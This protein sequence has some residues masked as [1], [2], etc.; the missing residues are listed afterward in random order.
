MP[1]TPVDASTRRPKRRWFQFSLRTLLIVV[2][3]LAVWLGLRVDRANRQQEAVEAIE[4]QGGDVYYDYQQKPAAKSVWGLTYVDKTYSSQVDPP[5]AEWLRQLV[6]ERF[7]VT[8]VTVMISRQPTICLTPLRDLPHLEEVRLSDTELSDFDVAN[9]AHLKKLRFL[10]ITWS[11][12]SEGGPQDFSFLSHLTELEWLQIAGCRFSEAGLEHLKHAGKLQTLHVPD[13]QI[14][15]D[16]LASLEHLSNL[17]V[18]G[19]RGNPITDDGLVHIA[20]LNKLIWLLLNGTQVTDEGLK[21]LEGLSGLR[22]LNLSKT[23]VTDEGLKCLE[24]LSGLRLLDLRK[25]Q[26]TAAGAERLQQALP[27]CKVIQ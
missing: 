9:L 10:S 19:L 21:C 20:S 6:G 25:T 15:D 14:S 13:H 22:F 24:G 26:V 1:E 11:R 17:E 8:P 12:S 7:F 4:D 2:T 23:Q 3:A 16:G 5:G 27:R 18:L